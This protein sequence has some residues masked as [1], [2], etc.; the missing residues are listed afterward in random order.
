MTA[1]ASRL[2]GRVAVVTG[3]SRGIGR[4]I[5]LALGRHGA[6]VALSF[7]SH[8]QDAR[9]VVDELTGA[10]ARAVALRCDVANEPDVGAFF[11]RIVATLGGVDI[12]VNNAG[13]VQSAA[14][15]FMTSENWREVLGVNLDGTFFCTKAA[16]RGMMVRR[17]GRIVN[18]VS[19]SGTVGLPGQAN[20]AASKA[21]VVGLTRT[22]ARELAPHG[23]LVNAVSPGLIETDMT[24]AMPERT[25]DALL[26]RIALAR[27]GRVDEVAPLVTFLVSEEASYITGQVIAVDGG[28]F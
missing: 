24:A 27:A 14:F 4:A 11:D 20:Y 8:E 21:G 28:L 19:A 10:G 6:A 17:W 18:V 7:K 2:E 26:Q 5:A 15:L 13:A 9:Q 12:L 22:L 1:V 25:R 16:V 3:G 23:V